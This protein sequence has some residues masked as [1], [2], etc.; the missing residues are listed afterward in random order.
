[1][2]AQ[3]AS[4]ISG[5]WSSSIQQASWSCQQTVAGSAARRRR[6]SLRATLPPGRSRRGGRCSAWLAGTSDQPGLDAGSG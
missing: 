1:L 4:G 5:V 2:T 6:A 3:R